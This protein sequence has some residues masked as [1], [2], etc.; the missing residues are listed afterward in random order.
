MI[1]CINETLVDQTAGM[2]YVMKHL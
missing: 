1:H 2:V